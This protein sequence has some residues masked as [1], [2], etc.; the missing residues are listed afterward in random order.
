MA[1]DGLGFGDDVLDRALQ[2]GDVFRRLN[3]AGEIQQGGL[4]MTDMQMRLLEKVE[5]LTLYT[6]DQQKT[7]EELQERLGNLATLG[8]LAHLEVAV[9]NLQ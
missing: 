9:G 4:N 5:E 3:I 8:C 6:L 2:I 7:I 1:V